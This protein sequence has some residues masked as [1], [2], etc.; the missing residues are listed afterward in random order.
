MISDK[1]T[2]VLGYRLYVNDKGGKTK[3]KSLSNI[4]R[5]MLDRRKGLT[6]SPFL[7]LEKIR[8]FTMFIKHLSQ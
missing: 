6:S 1:E 7:G 3:R 2:G 8:R 5:S 4:M